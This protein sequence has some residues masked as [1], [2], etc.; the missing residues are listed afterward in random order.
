MSWRSRPGYCASPS[1]ACSAFLRKGLCVDEEE[2]R[3]VI[4]LAS[5]LEQMLTIKEAA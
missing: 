1:R 5:D 3:A 4:E 2:F